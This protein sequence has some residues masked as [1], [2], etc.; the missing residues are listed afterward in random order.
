MN[1]HVVA[2]GVTLTPVGDSFALHVYLA[3]ED[4]ET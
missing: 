4:P 3:N 2:S 1:Q